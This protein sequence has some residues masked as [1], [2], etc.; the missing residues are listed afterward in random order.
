MVKMNKGKI[1][2]YIVFDTETGGLLKKDKLAVLDVALTEIALV[3][4][5]ADLKVVDTYSSLI[6]P[7]NEEAEYSVGAAEVSGIT[8]QDCINDGKSIV[9]VVKEII[10]WIEYNNK[11]GKKPVLVGHNLRAF[12]SY[13]IENLFV[14]GGEEIYDYTSTLLIDTLE[15]SW[16]IFPE[17]PNYQLGTMCKQFDIELVAAH[18]ALPDTIANTKLFIKYM[19]NYRGEGVSETDT[20]KEHKRF[21]DD[22]K[23]I[24]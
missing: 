11:S 5:N 10:D 16:K 24:F 1:Q 21:R 23:F 3:Y 6:K 2:D 9:V 14:F 19:K 18:R 8:K 22:E 20:F 7:Y 4:V 13:F 15:E 12:D 17:A